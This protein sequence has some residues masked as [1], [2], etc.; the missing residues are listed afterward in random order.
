MIGGIGCSRLRPR[1]RLTRAF[2]KEQQT[3]T[4]D[5]EGYNFVET[6]LLKI[7]CLCNIYNNFNLQHVTLYH[8][9]VY[10]SIVYHSIAY[11]IISYHIPSATAA[12]PPGSRLPGRGTTSPR[13][14]RRS[15]RKHPKSKF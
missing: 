5:R 1:G 15:R 14:P 10:Y 7:V 11:H 8:S 13:P 9:I 12:E 6:L 3:N 2:P 4:E